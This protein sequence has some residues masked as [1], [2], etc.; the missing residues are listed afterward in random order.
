MKISIITAV[1]NRADFIE[2][3][4]LSL[5]NQSWKNV[6]HVIIDGA[7]TDGTLDILLRLRQKNDLLISEPDIGLYYALNKGLKL[8][9]GDII[10][11]LHSDDFYADNKALEL[12]AKAFSDPNVDMVYGDLNYVSRYNSKKIIRR[13]RSEKFTPIKLRYGWMPPHPTLFIRR[14]LYEKKGGFNCDFK[15]SADYELILR[16]FSNFDRGFVYLPHTI[17]NMRLGGESNKSLS[18]IC[19]KTKEDYLALK[20]NRAGGIVAIIYKNIVKLPQFL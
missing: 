19:Q 20:Q 1:Y 4:I 10:G 3:A 11:V 2:E 8:T 13:W 15:I 12:V 14:S 16:Y 7:S 18:K 17:M 5:R 9:T 6:E